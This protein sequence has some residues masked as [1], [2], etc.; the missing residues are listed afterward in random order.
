[1]HLRYIIRRA[2]G[3]RTHF[4]Q[5]YMY[6]CHAHATQ[7]AGHR[8]WYM[9]L[10]IYLYICRHV[11]VAS[12]FL[13]C[14]GLVPREGCYVLLRAEPKEHSGLGHISSNYT[15]THVMHINTDGWPQKLVHVH[16]HTLVRMQTCNST[17]QGRYYPMHCKN[18]E[19]ADMY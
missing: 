13:Q 1:M 5:L 15:C 10:C 18:H 7:M 2:L 3:P 8:N 17:A 4:V 16:V 6:T 19:T 12:W 14:M 9:Y 11:I